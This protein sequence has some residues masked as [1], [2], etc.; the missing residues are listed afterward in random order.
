MIAAADRPLLNR[1]VTCPSCAHDTIVDPCAHCHTYLP[2]ALGG[3]R[4]P[5]QDPEP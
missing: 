1:A 3:T 4:T 5:S 2:K